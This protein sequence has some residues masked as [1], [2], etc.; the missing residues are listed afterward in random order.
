MFMLWLLHANQKSTIFRFNTNGWKCEDVNRSG[1][2]SSHG[3]LKNK[4]RYQ[5][6]GWGGLKNIGNVFVAFFS[7]HDDLVGRQSWIDGR[8]HEIGVKWESE[9]DGGGHLYMVVG[10]LIMVSLDY[11][12]KICIQT[13]QS[14][15]TIFVHDIIL[16]DGEIHG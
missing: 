1:R 10:T 16:T 13:C 2:W 6:V 14:Q 11:N 9:N 3:W 4:S 8:F 12:C 7:S 5:S 15:L